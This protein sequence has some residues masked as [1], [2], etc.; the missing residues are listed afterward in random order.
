LQQFDADKG[1]LYAG[2]AQAKARV[3]RTEQRRS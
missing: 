1:L 3:V 2:R